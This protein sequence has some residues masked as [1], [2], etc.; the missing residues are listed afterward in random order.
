MTGLCGSYVNII[1]ALFSLSI[2]I[3]VLLLLIVWP[4]TSVGNIKLPTLSSSFNI[5]F[6]RDTNTIE[7]ERICNVKKMKFGRPIDSIFS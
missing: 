1:L 2:H 7:I 3:W 6:N 4:K 5:R